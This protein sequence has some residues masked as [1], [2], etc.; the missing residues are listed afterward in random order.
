MRAIATQ[1]IRQDSCSLLESKIERVVQDEL[2][3]YF[4]NPS[5]DPL[6]YN[7]VEGKLYCGRD[8]LQLQYK[9]K[10]RAFRK[11]SPVVIEFG[12]AEV[13]EVEYVSRWFRPKLLIFKT[14]SPEKLKQFP[15]AKVGK[16]R[17]HVTK[18]AREDA[19]RAQVFIEYRQSEAYLRESDTR[20]SESRD[21][22]DSGL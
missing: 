6:G 5:T 17:L 3:V 11:N 1:A 13:Y 4:E 20:L 9:Q 14:R 2:S 21:E 15:G 12:Y 10:D 19:R 16:V 22:M 18:A 7:Q 8:N